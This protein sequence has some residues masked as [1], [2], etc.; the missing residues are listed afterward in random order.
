ME[1]VIE[2]TKLNTD[3]YYD[4]NNYAHSGFFL[5]EGNWLYFVEKQK[6][7]IINVIGHFDNVKD[8]AKPK[9]N[10]Q[11]NDNTVSENFT[12]RLTETIIQ[13]LK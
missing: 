2:I 5:T 6:S 13:N 4:I 3:N 11:K 10:D 7:H 12:I 1:L 9:E 8:F